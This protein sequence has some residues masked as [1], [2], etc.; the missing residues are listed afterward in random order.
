M[1]NIND[2]VAI[3][4]VLPPVILVLALVSFFVIAHNKMFFESRDLTLYF[5]VVTFVCLLM[6]NM[7][8]ILFVV[9]KIGKEETLVTCTTELPNKYKTLVK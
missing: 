9:T 6:F 1:E 3:S 4:I 2:I 8:L 5:I 7:S